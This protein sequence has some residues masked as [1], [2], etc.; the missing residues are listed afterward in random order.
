MVYT[1]ID[2]RN[3]VRKCSKLKWNRET[4]AEW[5]HCKVLDILWRHFYGL[6]ECRPWK[7][8]VDLF[9]TITNSNKYLSK[10]MPGREE[11]LPVG[12]KDSGPTRKNDNDIKEDKQEFKQ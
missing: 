3:D 10:A 7:N 6:L 1:L 2:H 11:T 5:F 4:L 9:Y 12:R 8:V